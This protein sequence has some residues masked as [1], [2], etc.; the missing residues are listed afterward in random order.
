M[1]QIET[2]RLLLRIPRPED[3]PALLD[4]VGDG[5]VMRWIGSEPGGLPVATEHVERWIRRW[6]ADGI[7][8]FV[9][10]LENDGR[11]L[12]RVGPLVWNARTW[13]TSSFDAAGDDAQVELGWA[14]AREH[15]GNGYATEAARAVRKWLYDTHGLERLIS[16]IDPEN[17]RSA[18]VAEKL[19]AEPAET[20]QT[21][22]GPAIVWVHPR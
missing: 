9:V 1:T 6:E 12:G 2:E 5:E 3:A 22:H 13:E 19:G 21:P 16:L 10:V 17:V 8:T 11:L 20:V 18:R 14:L 15:W 4:F 7:G